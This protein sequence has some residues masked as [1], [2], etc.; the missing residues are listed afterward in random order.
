[1]LCTVAGWSAA[2]LKL[3]LLSAYHS[4]DVQTGKAYTQLSWFGVRDGA[5]IGDGSVELVSL[6][7]TDAVFQNSRGQADYMTREPWSFSKRTESEELHTV[8]NN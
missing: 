4:S 6:Q 1:M 2:L 7:P 5:E 3:C 8:H